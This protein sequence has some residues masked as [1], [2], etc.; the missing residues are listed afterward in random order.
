MIE[1]QIVAQRM[2]RKQVE[3]FIFSF[4]GKLSCSRLDI[5][6]TPLGERIL[7]YTSKP[8][9]VVGRRGE[10]IKNLTIILKTRYGME[11]PQIEVAEIEEPNLDAVSMV[12]SIVGTF[13]RFGPKRFKAIAYN[14]LERIMSAGAIGAEV[15]VSGRGVPGVRAKTWR[16]TAGYLSKSGDT[17]ENYVNKAYETCH[18][19]SGAI[20][21]KVSI[22]HPKVELP[23]TVR[24]K[25]IRIVEDVLDDKGK[26][27]KVGKK[28]AGGKGGNN[29]KE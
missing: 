9:L 29:K 14:A 24:M 6:R 25:D 18:L 12:K 7:V 2:K 23:D 28:R 3:E 5:Q 15:V 19:R 11:N 22:L 1:R 27:A 13:E 16:F 8:G 20:G 26:K 17:S 4:L 10:N 21:I